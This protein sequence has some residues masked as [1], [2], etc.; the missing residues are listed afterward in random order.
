ML[1]NKHNFLATHLVWY[2]N[3]H[4][5]HSERQS[6]PKMRR[7]KKMSYYN[8]KSTKNSEGAGWMF[9]IFL[10][11]IVPL[12]LYNGWVLSVMWNWFVPNIFPTLPSLSI[13]EALGISLVVS[14]FIYVPQKTDENKNPWVRFLS[15]LLSPVL[16]GL[17]LLAIG[18]VVH[19]LAF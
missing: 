1:E 18:M 17:L 8:A 15:A 12:T 19:W 14:A 4:S 2:R 6:L 10:M 13:G 9:A 3:T 16:R 11:V 5:S 7:M